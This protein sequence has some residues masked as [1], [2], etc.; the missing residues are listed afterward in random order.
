VQGSDLITVNAGRGN[1]LR[2]WKQV[3]R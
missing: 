1:F 3:A 2:V